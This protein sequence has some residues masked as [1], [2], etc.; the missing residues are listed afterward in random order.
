MWSHKTTYVCFILLVTDSCLKMMVQQQFSSS[1][2]L[3]MTSQFSPGVLLV[4]WG[5][6]AVPDLYWSTTIA[7]VVWRCHRGIPDA[8]LA[9]HSNG[10]RFLGLE[11]S[12]PVSLTTLWD[13]DPSGAPVDR[14]RHRHLDVTRWTALFSPQPFLDALHRDTHRISQ[15]FMWNSD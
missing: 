12:L 4:W 7:D 14:L 11:W 9:S 6:S 15:Y 2:L 1:V 3:W 8:V 5:H 13:F 10:F